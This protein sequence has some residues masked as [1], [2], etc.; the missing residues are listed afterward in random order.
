[1][2]ITQKALSILLAL[3]M[4][5][6]LFAMNAAAGGDETIVKTITVS[7][8]CVPKVGQPVSVEGIKVSSGVNVGEIR[9]GKKDSDG[10]YQTIDGGTFALGKEYCIT[11]DFSVDDDLLDPDAEAFVRTDKAELQKIGPN[12][13]RLFYAYPPLKEQTTL[14]KAAITGIA[15]PVAGASTS[16][17]DAKITEGLTILALQ[18]FKEG[19]PGSFVKTNDKT[20][21]KGEVYGLSISF[22]A[23]FCYNLPI[24]TPFEI[25]GKTLE[26]EKPVDGFYD[27]WVEFPAVEAKTVKVSFDASPG[28]VSPT[29]K[30]VTVGQTYGSL[31][32]PSS[33]GRT[34]LGWYDGDTKVTSLTVVT[35]AEDHS[36]KAKWQQNN[37]V[38][39]DPAG[40]KV[41]PTSKSYPCGEAF[42]SLPTPTRDGYTFLWW[43]DE[44][45]I[46]VETTTTVP[47]QLNMKLTAKWQKEGGAYINVLFDAAGGTVDPMITTLELGAPYGDIPT[48]TRE[49][50]VF[51]GWYDA[52]NNLITKD[53]I[54][55][56]TNNK[57]LTAKWEKASSH[58][59]HVFD[60]P[61]VITKTP[62]CTEPGEKTY[63]C[64]ICGA[65]E[66]Q[67]I[68][69]LGHCYSI[70]IKKATLEKN[71]KI[72]K[73]CDLCGDVAAVKAIR[74]AWTFELF[75][76]KYTYSGKECVPKLTVYD[77]KGNVISAKYYKVKY[78]NNKN[79]GT[80]TV[81]VT[82]NTRYKGTKDVT[83]TIIPKGTSIK[84]L[85]PASKA[86]SVIWNKQTGIT[87]YQVQYATNSKFTKNVKTLTVRDKSAVKTSIGDLKSGTTYYV[88][89]RTYQTVAKK[90]Y[91]SL[92]SEAV[93]VKTK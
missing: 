34:F 5:T 9:W 46:V 66:T 75:K 26:V 70:K 20:F 43:V 47:N 77:Y 27:L 78:L 81:R 58:T 72:I 25:A 56:G 36:L 69:A 85:T 60:G 18:W 49:G 16:T 39:F 57:K 93:A 13:Y 28:L 88:R 64:S 14:A 30:T 92:W 51:K 3:L 7:G 53:S 45:N 40:G 82:F 17:E 24:G 87:G 55:A 62:T 50:Y 42:G 54:V 15:A 79:V 61:G 76:T 8:N 4:V 35:K 74:K 83:F 63:Y 31:P 21:V 86:F 41:D 11:V 48:P 37:L 52:E 22:K 19:M 59:E 89:V 33:S 90:N 67:P 23:D 1:M 65:S 12:T 71:G 29:T 73:S 10:N 38:T 68:P 2:K 6:S 80:A 84:K 44:N 91:C 32:I